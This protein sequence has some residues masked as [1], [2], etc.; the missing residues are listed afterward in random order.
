MG[1]GYG[2]T[3]HVAWREAALQRPDGVD[4]S[5]IA[6]RELQAAAHNRQ[7]QMNDP[8]IVA[9]QQLYIRGKMDMDEYQAYL[10]LKHSQPG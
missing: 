7:H 3:C 9:D 5:T 2:F 10:L 4:D 1:S 6:Q 8:E